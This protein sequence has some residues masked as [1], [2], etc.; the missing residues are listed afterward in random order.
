M[1]I[2]VIAD[3]PA[4]YDVRRPRDARPA[5]ASTSDV[6]AARPGDLP[7]AHV[8]AMPRDRRREPR[9]ARRPRSQAP[10]PAAPRWPLG[11]FDNTPANLAAWLKGPAGLEA[12]LLHA[13]PPARRRCRWPIWS[14]TSGDAPMTEA[15]RAVRVVHHRRDHKKIGI[16]YLL[17][18]LAFFAVRA[19]A[20][21]A[22]PPARGAATIHLVSPD[23]FNQLFTMHGTTMI[24]LVVMP[25]LN[26]FANYFVPPHDRRARPW[27]S[28]R[29]NAFGFW[30]FP[31]GGA[32]SALQPAGRRWPVGG[33][34]QLRA[35][36]RDTVLAVERHRLPGARAAAC[37][38]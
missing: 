20:G 33:L 1:R 28:P 15:A 4:A 37:S 35:A 17:T 13:E 25:L 34:V 21:H 7:G 2:R 16:L 9:R 6:R 36:Q 26:G 8:H 29:L 3:P 10:G 5:M 18:A 31:L 23:T 12:R 30:L 32:L 22:T 11:L 24:F 38:A 14:P 27:R 19:R